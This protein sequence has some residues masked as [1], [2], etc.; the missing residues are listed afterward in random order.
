M[1]PEVFVPKHEVRIE[2]E[3]GKRNKHIVKDKSNNQLRPMDPADVAAMWA[4]GN[5]RAVGLL[6]EADVGSTCLVAQ[7]GGSTYKICI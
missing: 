5:V 2:V 3:E 1:E 6:L 7:V 4:N